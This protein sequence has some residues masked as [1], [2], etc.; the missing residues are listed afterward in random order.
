MDSIIIS[1]ALDEALAANCFVIVLVLVKRV[2][3]KKPEI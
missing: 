1:K 2:R 3:L